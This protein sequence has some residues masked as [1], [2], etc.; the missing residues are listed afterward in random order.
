MC[1]RLAWR[2]GLNRKLVCTRYCNVCGCVERQT[3]PSVLDSKKHPNLTTGHSNIHTV[4]WL[5]FSAVY[6]H[7]RAASHK[8]GIAQQQISLRQFAKAIQHPLSH[9]QN[10][11]TAEKHHAMLSGRPAESPRLQMR[12]YRHV[13]AFA[14][15]TRH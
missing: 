2:L 12:F 13:S 5:T 15:W 10:T 11:T 6:G 8:I 3:R 7:G 9:Y 14:N 1:Q 4:G